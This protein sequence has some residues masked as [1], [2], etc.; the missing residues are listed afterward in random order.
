M[1]IVPSR[2]GVSTT[3]TIIRGVVYTIMWHTHT[4]GTERRR[5]LYIK[6]KRENEYS[7]SIWK[8]PVCAA[9]DRFARLE[10][11]PPPAF[12]SNPVTILYI[13]VRTQSSSTSAALLFSLPRRVF[14]KRLPPLRCSLSLSEITFCSISYY[15]AKTNKTDRALFR[16]S[17]VKLRCVRRFLSFF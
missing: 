14:D 15:N 8:R 17:A 13:R 6:I 5:T 2:F 16:K 4:R 11:S 1:P 7:S 12:C 10:F 9:D 3:V